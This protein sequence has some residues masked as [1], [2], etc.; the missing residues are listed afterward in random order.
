MSIILY[1]LSKKRQDFFID[2]ILKGNGIINLIFVFLI[3]SFLILESW[4]FIYRDGSSFF[5]D[6]SWYPSEGQFNMQ[7]MIIST[8]MV[9]LGSLVLAAPLGLFTALFISFYSS[10]KIS[11]FFQRL[12]ELYA[13]IPSV[14]FGFWGLM[15]IVPLI[16][17]INPPG[18]SLLAGIFILT[19]MIFPIITI[20]LVSHFE[21]ASKKH[22]LISD[23]LGLSKSTYIW[24]ILIPSSKRQLMS[25]NI[26]ALGRAMGETMAV[27][28]VCGN[29]VKIPTSLFDPIRTLTANMALEMSYAVDQH[30]SA[31]FLSG[32]V[33]LC[34]II[35]LIALSTQLRSHHNE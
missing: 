11:W 21:L 30:R 20:N 18:Q 17:K 26:L 1:Q 5:L 2:L 16:N 8:I 7:A 19:L 29:I 15:N 24:K 22:L 10:L 12:V 32:F 23:S 4:Q 28:M 25:A 27:L 35:T 6:N 34:L 14:I 31:L 3:F 9:S 33:L 13:G